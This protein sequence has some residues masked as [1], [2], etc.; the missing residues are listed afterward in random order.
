MTTPQVLGERYEIGGVLGRGGMAEVHRGRDLRLGR[1]VAVKVLRSDLA[2]D[3]SFQVRFRREAQAAASL[4][5]PAIVAVYDT[6]EDRSASGATPYIVMEYVEGQTLRDVLRGEGVLSPE[7]AMSLTADICGALDFSHRNGIVHRDVK[8]GNVMITPQG[9]VKVMDFGIARAVSDSA[10]T[11][12]STAAVIGTAQYLSPEQARGEGVDA[13]SDVYSVGCLLYELVTGAPPFTGDSPVAVAYQHVREDPRLPSSIN[14][15]IPPEL[16]AILLKAMSKNPANRYQSAADMRNDLLRALAGQQVEATPVMN[17]AEKTTILGATPGY[18]GGDW[19]AGDDEAA[20][21]RRRTRVVVAVVAAVLLLGGVITAAL[22][23]D[24]GAEEE[25]P[26]AREVAVPTLV[27]LPRAEAEAAITDAGLV[28]GAVTTEV[29]TDEAR[30]G[31]VLSSTPASGAR[32]DEGTRVDLVVGAAP[33]SIAIPPVV[34]LD[35]DDARTALE[36]AGLTG[37]INRDTVDSLEPEGT[38]VAVDPEQGTQVAPDVTITLSVSDGDA[39]VRDVVGQQQDAATQALRTDGFTNVQVEQVEDERPAGTVVATSPTGG[40]QATADTRITL[41]VSSGP[42][43]PETVPVPNVVDQ[44]Q[45]AATSTL[46]GLGLVV[47]V[48]QQDSDQADVGLVIS[49][50]PSA[51]TEV[52]PGSTV[53]ITV[54]RA[55]QGGG[56]TGTP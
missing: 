4:N 30:V 35:E 23:L 14:P 22:L 19:D 56:E 52:Q 20:R 28:V 54:G 48:V 8:P 18:A 31:T 42:A 32:V 16:D 25:A 7:R 6:G 17:D 46:Q 5:H 33:D 49:Q 10:A 43:E 21:K 27:D 3:P 26:V 51:D 34:N 9:S 1:E 39:E 53:T 11:M 2:R 24:S 44:P 45:A 47:N 41:R 38:V 50:N 13:R 37:N 55:P 12:T 40:S 15:A 29:T 36:N